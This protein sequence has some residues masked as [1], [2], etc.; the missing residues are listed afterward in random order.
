M[1]KALKD[2]EKLMW[3]VFKKHDGE[4]VVANS[5]EIKAK[6]ISCSGWEVRSDLMLWGVDIGVNDLQGGPRKVK[7]TTILLVTFECVGK[8]NDFWQM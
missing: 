5:V 4:V 2:I 8:I 7:P 1:V 3:H 6:G